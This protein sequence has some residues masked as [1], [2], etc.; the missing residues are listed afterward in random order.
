MIRAGWVLSTL[1]ILALGACHPVHEVPLLTLNQALQATDRRPE[2]L[3]LTFDPALVQQTHVEVPSSVPLSTSYR[4]RTGASAMTVVPQELGYFFS[5]VTPAPACPVRLHVTGIEAK[6]DV[7]MTIY[8]QH[9]TRALMLAMALMPGSMT[10]APLAGRG[11][12]KA[13]MKRDEANQALFRGLAVESSEVPYEQQMGKAWAK[14]LTA[15]TWDLGRQIVARLP[16]PATS[17]AT[18]VPTQSTGSAPP[19]QAPGAPPAL[20][21][22]PVHSP[23]EYPPV[24]YYPPP[25]QPLASATPAPGTH[26]H[27]G[28]FLRMFGGPG[29]GKL[30]SSGRSYDGFAMGVGWAIGGAL[31]DNLILFAEENGLVMPAAVKATD[32][33]SGEPLGLMMLGAGMSYYFMPHNLFLSGSVLGAFQPSVKRDSTSDV[34]RLSPGVG[35]KLMVGKEWWASANWGLG[36]AAHLIYARMGEQDDSSIRWNVM[37]FGA[38]FVATYN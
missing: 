30:G 33:S 3:S 9:H 11:E 12:G 2:C 1:G 28:F 16:P 6:V 20:P 25:G 31:T 32:S 5:T 13:G 10:W 22:A 26:R 14:A 19:V 37:A 29:Y 7:G 23:A 35:G 24:G 38:S 36:A 27:D 8:D 17:P 34:P 18:T 21:S 4:L 15:A